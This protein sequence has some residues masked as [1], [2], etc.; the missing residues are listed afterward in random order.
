MLEYPKVLIVMAS[1][2]PIFSRP[3]SHKSGRN[4]LEYVKL[5]EIF[6]DLG[7]SLLKN[8]YSGFSTTQT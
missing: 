3:G 8:S 2:N 1:G 4:L 6:H 5:N 7:C